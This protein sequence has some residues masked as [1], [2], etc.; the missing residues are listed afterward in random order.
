MQKLQDKQSWRYMQCIKNNEQYYNST[1]VKYCFQE[2]WQKARSLFFFLFP[3]NIRFSAQFAV[4]HE[5]MGLKM[6]F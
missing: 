1:K 4:N 5:I 3:M 6:H 2:F